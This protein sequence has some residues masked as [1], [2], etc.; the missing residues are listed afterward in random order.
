MNPAA[1]KVIKHPLPTPEMSRSEYHRIHRMYG[2]EI[3]GRCWVC[4][5]PAHEYP[6]EMRRVKNG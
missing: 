4:F 6:E 5:P 2:Y 3:D 1:A